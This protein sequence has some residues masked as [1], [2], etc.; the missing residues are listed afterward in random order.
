MISALRGQRVNQLHQCAAID[1]G[2]IEGGGAAC[3]VV[4]S[5]EFKLQLAFPESDNLKVELST[6]ESLRLVCP[7]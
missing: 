3:K 6:S 5:S 7:E 2:I 1:F 4:V